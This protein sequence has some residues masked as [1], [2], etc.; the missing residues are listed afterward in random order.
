MLLYNIA[1]ASLLAYARIGLEM[2]GAG[3]LPAATLHTG[4]AV[5]CIACLR[6]ARAAR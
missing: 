2:P 5:W 4:L 6:T 1:A 3:L